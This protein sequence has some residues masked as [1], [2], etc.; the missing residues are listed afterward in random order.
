MTSVLA[1]TI[2]G[3]RV[4]KAFAQERREVERFRQANDRV[5]QAN[6]RVNTLWSFFGPSCRVFDRRRRVGG[7]G[8][9]RL[10]DHSRRKS[11][12]ANCGLCLS[13]PSADF[14]CAWIR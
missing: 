7:V 14:T 8:I 12:L 10:S 9:W 11:M 4:V 2:P 5:F 13:P 6:N 3:I 1:D